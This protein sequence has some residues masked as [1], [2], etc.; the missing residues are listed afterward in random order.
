MGKRLIGSVGLKPG[1]DTGFDLDEKGQIHG[2][3]DQQFALPVGDDD[4][5]LTAD[6]GEDSGL[7]WTA[8]GGGQMELLETVTLGSADTNIAIDSMTY[9]WDDYSMFMIALNC[10][11][12]TDD[13]K[14]L[15]FRIDNLSTDVYAQSTILNDDSTI[16]G[17]SANGASEFQL[18]STTIIANNSQPKVTMIY[19]Q[20]PDLGNV[21]PTISNIITQ[22]NTPSKNESNIGMQAGTASST[23]SKFDIFLSNG[24]TFRTGGNAILYGLKRT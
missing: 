20:A 24:D 22:A 1:T 13:A 14:I 6:S 2:Y 18:G 7:K 9:S 10:R 12:T 19:L 11:E 16:S 3:S 5:V 23:F 4:Q 21:Y 8:A 17:S 15:Q